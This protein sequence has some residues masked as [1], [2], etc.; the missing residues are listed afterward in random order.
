[1]VRS[2][3]VCVWGGSLCFSYTCVHTPTK[4]VY[5]APVSCISNP[6][7]CSTA[8]MISTSTEPLTGLMKREKTLRS[9]ASAETTKTTTRDSVSVG[10][11][12]L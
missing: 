7:W 9:F 10:L 1:M 6:R 2:V 11:K 5:Y 3:F 12:S 8:A 4:V